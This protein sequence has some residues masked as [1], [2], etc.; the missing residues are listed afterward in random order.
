[1]SNMK[2][3]VLSGGKGT[4]LRPLPY[5]GAKQLVPIANRP[6][7]AYVLDNIAA[8]GIKEV[9]II[10]SPETGQ[11]VK[12]TMGDGS[13]WGV[14]ITYIMQAEPKGL[15]H[16]V[17]TASEARGHP[18]VLRRGPDGRRG[19]H[20]LPRGEAE[21][22]QEQPRARGRLHILE[23]D[24][25]GHLPDKALCKGRARDNGRHTG[26]HKPG[27]ASSQPRARHLVARHRKEGRPPRSEH[28]RPG[29]VVQEGHKRQG[30]EP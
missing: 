12:E 30:R 16:A 27:Q 6:I 22:P 24:P 3:I 28:H 8:V 1:M 7:L 14:A 5:P 29:R 9:G 13:K 10:I 11:E 19:P 26:A 23:G 25:Q 15:A 2:A 17:V 18:P 21:E 4:R 20:N